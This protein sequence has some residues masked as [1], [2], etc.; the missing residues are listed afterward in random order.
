LQSGTAA[1]RRNHETQQEREIATGFINSA[2][3]HEHLLRQLPKVKLYYHQRQ[4]KL[5]IT[6]NES[7][8]R[9]ADSATNKINR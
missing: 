2:R 8:N 4:S 5:G 9:F 3:F 7:E 1:K 6:W